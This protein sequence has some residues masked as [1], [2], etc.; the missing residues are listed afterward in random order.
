[1][2]E[3]N[4]WKSLQKVPLVGQGWDH[5]GVSGKLFFIKLKF[6]GPESMG[7]DWILWCHFQ[8]P[9]HPSIC[10][11][12]ALNSTA[13]NQTLGTRCFQDVHCACCWLKLCNFRDQSIPSYAVC[14]Y[15]FTTLK[16]I[17]I[18]LCFFPLPSVLLLLCFPFHLLHFVLFLQGSL[19]FLVW[20][21]E[22]P[23]NYQTLPTPIS[24]SS[25][26]RVQYQKLPGSSFFEDS[27][28]L[29]W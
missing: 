11:C 15:L 29:P 26:S 25:S 6:E 10:S 13:K 8:V 3:R 19:P 18:C 1:M 24:Y 17:V 2:A 22:P 21:L 20:H 14:V 12:V 23:W 9:Q 16:G 27:L 28:R 5:S 7:L 4:L